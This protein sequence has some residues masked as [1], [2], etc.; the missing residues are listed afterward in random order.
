MPSIDD[1]MGADLRRWRRFGVGKIGGSARPLPPLFEQPPAPEQRQ[2]NMRAPPEFSEAGPMSRAPN[3]QSRG[4]ATAPSVYRELLLEVDRGGSQWSPWPAIGEWQW[5]RAFTSRRISLKLH[6]AHLHNIVAS[7]FLPGSEVLTPSPLA[8]KPSIRLRVLY[9]TLSGTSED[10]PGSTASPALHAPTY[11]DEGGSST[12]VVVSRSLSS[13]VVA[14]SCAC[15]K[16]VLHARRIPPNMHASQIRHE[17]RFTHPSWVR[18]RVS[19]GRPDLDH[20]SRG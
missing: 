17:A 7:R 19:A 20:E 18:I 16:S 13:L 1:G 12:H 2:A 14:S 8:Q 4:A 5:S 10:V 9:L 11:R 15:P 3:S 6:A